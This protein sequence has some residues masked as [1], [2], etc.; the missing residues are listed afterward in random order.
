MTIT[1]YAQNFEDVILW[2]ALKHVEHGFYIDIG[3]QD[4]VVDSVSLA[5]YE[6]GW[7]GLHVEPTPHYAEKLRDARPDE[8]VIEAAIGGTEQPLRLFEIADT[9]LSTGNEEIAQGHIAKGFSVRSVEVPC[10]PLSQLL[11]AQGGRTIHWLKI[12]VEGM[13]EQVIASWAPSPARPWIVAVESTDPSSPEETFNTWEPLLIALGYE[14][15]YFDGLNRFY[16]SLEHQDLKASFGPGP[17]VFDGFVLSG[18]SS[19]SFCGKVSADRIALQQQ[20]A[21]RTE[22]MARLS[23]V[24]DEAAAR[25]KVLAERLA[26]RDREIAQLAQEC[27]AAQQSLAAVHSST[28]WRLTAPLRAF[29]RKAASPLEGIWAW[30]TLKPGSRPRR[31][32]RKALTGLADWLRA[33]PRLRS[34]LINRLRRYP[35]LFERFRRMARAQRLASGASPSAEMFSGGGSAQFADLSPDAKMLYRRLRLSIDQ[36]QSK[37]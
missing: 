32:A 12:D 1:S 25:E 27:S 15:A 29:K 14:F 20:L 2:R 19:A 10:M 3:A 4:P 17:N 23:Q 9:G 8:T 34:A 31:V 37:A 24:V 6:Q 5:F 22:E 35:A 36:Q 13:E 16:V 21:A 28:S 11:D 30:I 18:L 7:R 33:R 26:V